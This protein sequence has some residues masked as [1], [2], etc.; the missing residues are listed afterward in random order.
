VDQKKQVLCKA[1]H[2]VELDK[3]AFHVCHAHQFDHEPEE[4]GAVKTTH[5]VELDKEVI[6]IYHAPPLQS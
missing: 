1:T 2:V 3:K 4:A 6:V 5:V